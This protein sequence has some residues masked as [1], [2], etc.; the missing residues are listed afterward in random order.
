M[1]SLTAW[2]TATVAWLVVCAVLMSIPMTADNG[3]ARAITGTLAVFGIGLLSIGYYVFGLWWWL[4]TF[5]V[6]RWIWQKVVG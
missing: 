2:L 3:N 6:W 1:A 4:N 5:G